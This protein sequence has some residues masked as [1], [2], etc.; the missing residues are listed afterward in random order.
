MLGYQIFKYKSL[1][2]H[3][4]SKVD[5]ESIKDIL[6]KIAFIDKT[7]ANIVATWEDRIELMNS[8]YQLKVKFLL[9]QLYN[10][11]KKILIKLT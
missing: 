3:L 1:V 11:L 8:N 2:E 4:L 10:I 6:I 9:K 7:I 5:N